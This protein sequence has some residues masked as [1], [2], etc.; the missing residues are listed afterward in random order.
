VTIADKNAASATAAGTIAT[1]TITN[2]GAAVVNSGALTT[3][4]LGGTLTTVNAGTLG[5]LTTPANTALALNLTGAKSTGAVTIDT[6]IKTLNVT[7]STTASSINTL[8]AQGA[9]AITVAGDAKVTFTANTTPNVASIVVTNT[10]GAAFGT[11]LAAGV[12]FTGGAGADSVSLANAFEKAIDMGAGNDKVTY[13][14]AASTTTGKLGSV[15]AADGTDTIVMSGAEADAA[16]GDSVFNASFTGFEVLE[17]EDA[18]GVTV[19]LDGIN[20]ASKVVFALGSN[21]ATINNLAS[22]GTVELKANG[23][24]NLTVGI[25][26]AVVGASDVLNLSLL[27]TTGTTF[28]TIAAANVETVNISVPDAA[29]T[30]TPATNAVV[31]T[32]SSLSAAAA[33]TVTVTGNN[34]V[35]FT[36][37]TASKLTSFDATGVVANNTEDSAGFAATSDTGANLA[38]TFTSA[39]TTTTAAVSIKGGAGNDVLTGNA[40]IDTIEGGKGADLV[41]GAG[42][43]DTLV[44]GVGRDVVLIDSR[45]TVSTDSSTAAPDSVQG[46]VMGSAFNTATNLIDATAWAAGTAVGTNASA[47]GI[48]LTQAGGGNQAIAVEGNATGVGVAAGVNFKVASGVLTLSGAGASAVDTLGEWLTEAA[49]VAAANGDILAFEFSGNTYVFAQNGNAD[50][51]VSLVGITGAAAL[52]EGANTNAS[53]VANT[54]YFLDL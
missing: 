8:D 49:A 38:V 2:A 11:A 41:K 37:N 53:G 6:D 1:V 17:L 3:L 46:F 34:G 14:G 9:T 13:G 15:A 7:G 16:D 43:A 25:K 28:N 52:V 22:G 18:T 54:I 10:G 27:N 36:A 50:V 44:V 40:A 4:N 42:G 26:G 21:G 47:L 31:H 19:D 45:D 29:P 51:L 20:G 48:D 35:T 39:N 30:G 32:I 12:S 23:A 5:A 24:G 33:K